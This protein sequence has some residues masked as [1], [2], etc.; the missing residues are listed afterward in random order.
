MAK[1]EKLLRK[2]TMKNV[3]V[4]I[5]SLDKMKANLQIMKPT[6][7]FLPVY[8]DKDMHKYYPADALPECLLII[9]RKVNQKV[10]IMKL[11]CVKFA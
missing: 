5:N 7:L 6:F 1:K 8:K 2:L 9:G 11:L 4:Y 10:K 3:D